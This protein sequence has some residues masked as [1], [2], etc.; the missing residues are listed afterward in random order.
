M[1]KVTRLNGEEF[2]LNPHL[3][4]RIESKADTIITM[5]SQIQ[6]IVKEKFDEIYSSILNYRKKISIGGQE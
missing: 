5:H 6:Y 1:I 4:E 2:Y 3:I